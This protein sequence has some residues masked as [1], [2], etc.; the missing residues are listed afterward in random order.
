M[1]KKHFA[2]TGYRGQDYARYMEDNYNRKREQRAQNQQVHTFVKA[3]G[4]QYKQGA[5]QGKQE[6]LISI[7]YA[8]FVYLKFSLE[9]IIT[10]SNISS[11]MMVHKSPTK[12]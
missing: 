11:S 10:R 7:L 5:F 2:N 8:L 9:K 1:D 12:S 4:S 3:E 6:Y